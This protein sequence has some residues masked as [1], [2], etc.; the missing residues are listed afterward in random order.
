[1]QASVHPPFGPEHAEVYEVT[2][3]HRGKDWPGEARDVVRKVR[4][5]LPGASSLLD[6][7][8]GTGAHLEV[9]RSSF[10]HVE[11]LELAPAMREQAARR[12]PGVPIHPSDMRNFDLGRPFHA[13]TSLFTAISYLGTV[14]EL[15]AAVGC[16]AKHLVSGGVIAVEPWWLPEQYI[17]GYVGSDLVHD[18]DRV[19]ARVSHTARLG[20]AAN[21]EARWLVA[22]R[23]GIRAF[24]VTEVFTLFTRDEYLAAFADAGCAVDYEEG[25]LTGRG[26]F[27]GVRR[28]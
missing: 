26:I 3:R 23:S 17:D 19:V 18:G 28:A 21:L 16:M 2:Y 22:D 8:C 27:V 11:G 20:R 25:W 7:G 13:V 14:E 12:L 4:H 24:T 6:V 10:D 9:F 5:R 1:M 15:R